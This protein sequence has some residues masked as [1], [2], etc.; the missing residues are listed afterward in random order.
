MACTQ[1]Q[2]GL[3]GFG[4]LAV[5]VSLLACGIEA[6]QV[7]E[8]E[9][10]VH[11]VDAEARQVRIAHEDI[12]GFMPG[13]TMVFDVADPALLQ[14][15]EPGHPIRFELKRRGASLRITGIAVLG[16]AT[17]PPGV[18]SQ[19]PPGLV[20]APDFELTD[21]RGQ[22]FSLTQLRGKAVLLDF[23][24]TR[25]A[26]PCPLLTRAHAEVQRALG[27]GVRERTHF[28][29]VSLDPEYDT[30][31]RLAA[32]G[33]KLGCDLETWSFL[34]GSA[35]EVQSVIDAYHIGTV[36][37]PDG[38]LDHQV[39]TLLI[40]PHGQIAQRYLGLEHPPAQIVENLQGLL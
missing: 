35:E 3:H 21:H 27:D 1:P 4:A 9:G 8:V 13:M 18:S 26:G 10:V 19:R 14:G 24:F 29:S 23:I 22:R 36:R 17:L 28:V 5:L 33:R 32:Y 34:T 30:P 16:P 7:Y 15:L 20:E 11:A 2:T 31:E 39:P 6:E 38:S 12:P 40:D 37:Q 25:C